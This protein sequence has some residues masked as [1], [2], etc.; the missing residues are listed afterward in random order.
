M[1]RSVPKY[2]TISSPEEARADVLVE[3]D[4]S[5]GVGMIELVRLGVVPV[6]AAVSASWWAGRQLMER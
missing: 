5:A 4:P 2:S 1:S 6:L 3:P